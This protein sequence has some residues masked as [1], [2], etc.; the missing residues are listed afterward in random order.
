MRSSVRNAVERIFGAAGI[1]DT[2]LNSVSKNMNTGRAMVE[3]SAGRSA[4]IARLDIGFLPTS[5]VAS[6]GE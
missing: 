4:A 2:K 3:A 5:G 6:K 1:D